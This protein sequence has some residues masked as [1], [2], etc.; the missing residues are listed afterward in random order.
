WTGDVKG[1]KATPHVLVGTKEGKNLYYGKE[2]GDFVF[3]FEFKLGEGGNNGVGIR[4]PKGASSASYDG[5]ECQILDNA[6]DVYATI[7]PWQTH[8]SIYGVIPAKRG[9]LNAPGTWNQ[10]EITVRGNHF[11]VVLNG[12]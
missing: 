7:K 1:Y 10:Q 9:Y 3:R 8:G 11:K 2:F 5:I 4:V 12:K 6:A